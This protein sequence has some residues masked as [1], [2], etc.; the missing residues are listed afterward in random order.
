MRLRKHRV[1]LEDAYGLVWH[2]KTGLI[3][4]RLQIP[5]Y[6]LLHLAQLFVLSLQFR[7]ES[8]LLGVCLVESLSHLLQ[9]S[10]HFALF[11]L[12]LLVRVPQLLIVSLQQNYLRVFDQKQFLQHLVLFPNG[13]LSKALQIHLLFFVLFKSRLEEHQLVDPLLLSLTLLLQFPEHLLALCELG[14]VIGTL[15][16]KFVSLI[17]QSFD[18]T[19]DCSQLFLLLNALLVQTQIVLLEGLV[20]LAQLLYLPA[21]CEDFLSEPHFVAPKPEAR[22]LLKKVFFLFPDEKLEP[23]ELLG[24]AFLSTY[25]T[26]LLLFE[27]GLNAGLVEDMA[28][29]EGRESG[30]TRLQTATAF[31]NVVFLEQ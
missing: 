28:A 2:R 18:L 22:G 14:S 31:L 7:S 10:L 29:L 9:Q 4:H 8:L 27:P 1:F 26:G 21:L 13:L 15:A 16:L 11:L 3:L 30:K 12:D 20:F 5:L 24:P 17:E 23:G 19:L 6:H 25:G